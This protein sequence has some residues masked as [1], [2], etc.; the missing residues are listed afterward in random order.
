MNTFPNVAH[1]LRYLSYSLSLYK[2][3]HI[4]VINKARKVWFGPFC[5]IQYHLYDTETFVWVKE[6][7]S[8]LMEMYPQILISISPNKKI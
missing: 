8:R 5:S 1:L 3:G 4:S 6:G 2:I 7:F